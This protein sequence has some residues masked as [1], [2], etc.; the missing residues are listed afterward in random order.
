MFVAT[1][2]AP[3]TSQVDYCPADQLFLQYS[4]AESRVTPETAEYTERVEPADTNGDR[5]PTAGCHPIRK[6]LMRHTGLSMLSVLACLMAFSAAAP[7][8]SAQSS[9]WEHAFSDSGRWSQAFRKTGSQAMGRPQGAFSAGGL[10]SF[11]PQISVFDSTSFVSDGMGFGYP[12][13]RCYGGYYIPWPVVIQSPP[14]PY[15]RTPW[16]ST[17]VLYPAIPLAGS[18][19][20]SFCCSGVWATGP[21][22][23]VLAF[24]IVQSFSFQSISIQTGPLPVVGNHNAAAASGQPFAPPL[25]LQ[26]A[27]IPLAF[28]PADPRLLNLAAPA[29]GQLPV[30]P[31][32]FA[33][34]LPGVAA[35][36]VPETLPPEA[37]PDPDAAAQRVAAEGGIVLRGKRKLADRADRTLP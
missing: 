9:N 24:P 34:Q 23:G 26:A 17:G 1:N 16:G 11:A 25:P 21:C 15:W 7:Y 6:L 22:G 36:P 19:L 28:D 13:V 5:I 3:E 8:V 10:Y 29:P 30:K 32:A 20:E 18:P 14:L 27:H 35:Q 12:G 33:Q 4:L 37:V 2:A 31:A